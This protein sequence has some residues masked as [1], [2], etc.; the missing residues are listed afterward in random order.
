MQNP[1][2]VK[3]ITSKKFY[4]LL[5][6][7]FTDSAKTSSI[8][9]A[10]EKL[11]NVTTRLLGCD[12]G[13]IFINDPVSG[14]LYSFIAQGHLHFEIRILNNSGLAGW[15]FTHNEPLCIEDVES[16][17]RHNNY[18]DKVTG[19]RTKNVL[20]VPFKNMNNELIGV[21]QMLNK[22]EGRFTE[23][24]IKIVQAITKH[25][26]MAI[27]SK[28]TVEKIEAEHTKNTQFLN[29]ISTIFSEIN[30][31]TLLEK[32]IDTVKMALDAERATL[33]INDEQT[34]ELY[35]ESVIGISKEEIRFPNTLG[36]AGT[37]FTTGEIINIPHAYTDL[38]FNPSFDKKTGFFTRSILTVPV[39]NKNGEIIG[40][41]QVLNKRTGEFNTDDETQLVAI[42]SQI[43]IAIE[44]AKLF[45]E[46]KTIKNYNESI[47]ESMSNAVI[48]LNSNNQIATCNRAG[49]NL[50]QLRN[51]DEL[52]HKNVSL[53]FPADINHV[54][55]KINQVNSEAS[56]LQ[57]ESLMDVTLGLGKNEITVNITILPLLSANN[58]R[59]GVVIII[60]DISS[61]KRMKMTMSRYM[62]P[63]LAEKLLESGTFSLGGSSTVATVL[64]TDIRNFTT[65]SETLGAQETVKLLNE[66]FTLMVD[67]IHNEGGMLDKFIGDAMMAVFGNLLPHEDEPDRAVRSAIAMMR[68]LIVLNQKRAAL[69]LPPI[70]HGIGINT[71]KVVSGNIG[72]NKRM[73]FTVIGDGVNLAS[74]IESLCKHYGSYILISEF[75]YKRLKSTYRI[76]H[77]DKVVVKGKNKP[78]SIYEVN[79]FHD[80]NTFP[81]QIEV[82]NHFNNGIEFYSDALWDKAI[83]SFEAALQLFPEDKPSQVYID[84]CK[85]LKE[86]PPDSDWQGVWVM[87]SK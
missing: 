25:V 34:H 71:D 8:R 39:R 2:S 32:I 41:T 22:V 75:T 63:D 64:F 65:I 79:D 16:D 82:L 10:L 72:S 48:T 73:D 38:R 13:T 55:E 28:L 51:L 84:R 43:S 9:E 52:L 68:A 3:N 83:S 36:I 23:S 80:K 70:A 27:Q 58:E 26:A 46:V 61:E 85:I 57:Q 21:T 12:R 40:V 76:R 20:C 30:L 59:I 24:D 49:M 66:Y 69:D 50:F 7:I 1:I 78:V 74:R 77:I 5:S 42:N 31:S 60:E 4:Q 29:T 6:Q 86:S 44:N 18:F 56:I 47:L 33:F 14:E 19:F 87:K 37:S 54:V 67:C 11:V 17:D 81:N 45:D 62:S 35:T 53:L 15:A